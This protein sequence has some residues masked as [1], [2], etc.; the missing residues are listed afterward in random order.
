MA[1]CKFT[2]QFSNN[3]SNGLSH[4]LYTLIGLSWGHFKQIYDI[5]LSTEVVLPLGH[6]LVTP[7][8]CIVSDPFLGLHRA[9]VPWSSQ[10]EAATAPSCGMASEALYKAAS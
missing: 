8:L 9:A 3:L 4:T 2:E 7:P 5:L 1:F 6:V 10:L